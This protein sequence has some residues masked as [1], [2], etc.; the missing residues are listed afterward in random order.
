MITNYLFDYLNHRYCIDYF[1]LPNG[2]VYTEN[3]H[4]LV[5]EEWQPLV[6]KPKGWAQNLE[7]LFEE[8]IERKLEDSIAD[9]SNFFNLK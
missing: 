7:D 3:E 2:E 1:I 6:K 8:E 4:V 5:G 9:N